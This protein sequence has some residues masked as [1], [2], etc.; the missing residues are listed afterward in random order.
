MDLT[1]TVLEQK[2]RDELRAWLGGNVPTGWRA[3]HAAMKSIEERFAFIRAWQREVYD[4]GWAGVAW[5][6]QFGGRGAS[7]I[8]QVIYHEEMARAQAPLMANVLGIGIIGPTIIGWGTD[9]QKRRFLASILSGEEIW[10][11][12]FSEPGAGSDLAALR[13]EARRDGDDFLVSGHK[14][15][16]SY[17]WA[18]D[19]CALL[20]RTDPEAPRHKGLTYLLVDMHSP[21]VAVRPLRQMTGE[22]EFTEIL[23]DSV[24]VPAWNAL[25]SVNDGW[26]VAITTLMH[27][28]GTFGASL[29][30]NFKRQFDRLVELSHT[31]DRNGR[32]AA[33][34]PAIRQKLAQ[35]CA[36]VEIFRLTQMRAITRVSRS[37][38]PG[39]E[40]SILKIFWSEYMQRFQQVAAEILGPYSQLTEECAYAPD[41][42]Q[43]AHAFLRARGH[44]IEA[45]TSEIQRNIVGAYTLGLPKSY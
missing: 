8:E 37:G 13:T 35:C 28:R 39:A 21:G 9:E 30:V 32:P 15:W 42:G 7:L 17:G 4:A 34:D 41:A 1:L 25:G 11:Q 31:I 5:P 18:A 26:N 20:V 14:V 27:E 2:F 10:C 33:E 3:R 19:W 36:E 40:G 44:T 38:A 6:K 45:G 16:T 12:G 22:C 43:W 24:R 23:F 29:H